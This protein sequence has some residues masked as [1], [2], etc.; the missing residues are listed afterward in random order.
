MIAMR[1]GS[2]LFVV[3]F[4]G[5]VSMA[6]ETAAPADQSSA[7]AVEGIVLNYMGGGI[8]GATV[9]VEAL[10]AGPDDPPL[11][12]AVTNKMGNIEIALPQGITGKVRVRISKEG[13]TEFVSEVEVGDS[14]NPPF[15]DA[16]L[17]GSAVLTGIVQAAAD[18]RP[19]AKAQVKANSGGR[20]T[21]VT[22]DEEGRFT[23]NDVVRGVTA[24]TVTADGYAVYREG[25]KIESDRTETRIELK[26]ERT[27]ELILVTNRGEPAT[28]VFVEAI[29]LPM[30]H[31]VTTAPGAEGRVTLHGVSPEIGAI[32]LRLNGPRY[33]RMGEY[34]EMVELPPVPPTAT[35]PEDISAVSKKLV[36]TLAARLRGRVTEAGSGK[37]VVGVRV[38]AGRRVDTDA[39]VTWTNMDGE[40]ELAHIRPGFV[41]IS[42]QHPDYATFIREADLMTGKTTEMNVEISAGLPLGGQVIDDSGRPVEQVWISG[43]DW[44][45][46]ATL[47]LRAVSSADGGFLFK[48]APTGPITFSFQR[49]GQRRPHTETLESGKTNYRIVLPAVTTAPSDPAT[50]EAESMGLFAKIEPGRTVPEITLTSIDGAEYKLSALRGKYVF[51]DFWAT[52]CGPCRAEV[53]NIKALRQATKHRA[54]FV[55]IGVSLDQERENLDKFIQKEGIDWPQVCGPQSGAAEAFEA[56]CGVGIPY[57]CLIGPDGKLLEQ[58]LRGSGITEQVKK[59][60]PEK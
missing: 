13:Y 45:G 49:Q 59:H 54:D 53:P 55:L 7:P 48:H 25:V 33:V 14:A 58:H 60:L 42:F 9:R 28:E 22:T 32:L 38:L 56:F 10:E 43:D 39:P 21:N 36:V 3:M 23:V 44:K 29:L 6:D 17:S 2:W 57:T 26:P 24:L 40:Y 1:W 16:T 37:P 31:Y 4:L 52:W 18:G 41:P 27:V 19:I 46:Y 11:A 30:Q 50:P 51:L 34:T 20:E 47:G 15:V 8:D 12:E 5:A 35:R